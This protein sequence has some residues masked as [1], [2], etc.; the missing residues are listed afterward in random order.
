MLLDSSLDD[1]CDVLERGSVLIH[2]VVAQ[3]N[4]IASVSSV[5]HD[6]QHSV[7]M[8]TGL[9]KPMLLGRE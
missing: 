9:V 4:A 2:H 3:S 8:G 6:L 5:A 1:L 7:E